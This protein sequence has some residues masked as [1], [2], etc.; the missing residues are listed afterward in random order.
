MQHTKYCLH[1]EG[2]NNKKAL[3]ICSINLSFLEIGKVT[4]CLLDAFSCHFPLLFSTCAWP[5][6]T[7]A[8]LFSLIMILLTIVSSKSEDSLFKFPYGFQLLLT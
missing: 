7:T 3:T 4:C 6:N 8:K 1:A 5:Q 2:V